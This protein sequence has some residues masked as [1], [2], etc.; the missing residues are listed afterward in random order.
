MTFVIEWKRRLS[1]FYKS[2]LIVETGFF[3]DYFT[4]E[5]NLIVK[6]HVFKL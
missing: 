2:I 6:K 3:G 1:Y 5:M 4:N